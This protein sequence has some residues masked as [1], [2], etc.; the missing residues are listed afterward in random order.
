MSVKSDFS[1]KEG[2]KCNFKSARAVCKTEQN[3]YHSEFPYESYP[4]FIIFFNSK[5]K[6]GHQKTT[7]SVQIS[8]LLV[9]RFTNLQRLVL[10][11][12]CNLS[13]LLLLLLFLWSFLKTTSKDFFKYKC[14]YAV[15]ALPIMSDFTVLFLANSDFICSK[16][17]LKCS[18]VAV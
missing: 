1:C 7:I 5:Q 8:P 18:H 4:V 3:A 11:D 15:L 13:D 9:L 6:V 2:L 10:L 12:V 16:N 17:I 14:F